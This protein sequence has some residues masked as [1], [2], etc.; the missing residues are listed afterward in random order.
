M[1]NKS[2]KEQEID[3]LAKAIKMLDN[4]Y[5]QFVQIPSIDKINQ[6]RMLLY[7]LLIE[8]GYTLTQ[9]GKAIKK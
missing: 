5:I 4:M 2:Q 9:Q 6:A 8:N 7:E 3:A 1:A